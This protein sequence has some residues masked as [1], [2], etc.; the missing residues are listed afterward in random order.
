MPYPMT[1]LPTLADFVDKAKKHGIK[2]RETESV[3]TGPRGPVKFRYLY[4]EPSMIA[5]LPDIKDDDVLTPVVLR[6]ICRKLEI[7]V[8]DFGLHLG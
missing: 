8:E 6:S 4:K 1:P 3:T 2:L 7:P 5:I